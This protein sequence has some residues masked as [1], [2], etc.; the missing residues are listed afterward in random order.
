MNINSNY[1]TQ[2]VETKN[3][4][5][6]LVIY[7]E[8]L[9]KGDIKCLLIEAVMSHHVAYLKP[10]PIVLYDYYDTN[11]KATEYYEVKSQVRNICEGFDFAGE[12]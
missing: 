8:S 9:H 3:D 6:V 5:S 11:K 1:F 10:V 7:F 2:L 4:D 12:S